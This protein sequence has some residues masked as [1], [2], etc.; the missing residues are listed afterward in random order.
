MH[1][2]LRGRPEKIP[3]KPALAKPAFFIQSRKPWLINASGHGRGSSHDRNSA[4]RNRPAGRSR[5]GPDGNTPAAGCSKP[6]LA[7]RSRRVPAARTPG[8]E[9]GSSPGCP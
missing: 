7:A 5:P 1:L 6:G 9:P 2:I 8:P 4:G 3:K